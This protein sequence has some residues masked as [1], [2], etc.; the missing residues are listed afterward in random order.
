M[1]S[2][3]SKDHR[4]RY[5]VAI[6]GMG[7]VTPL[8]NTLGET[9]TGLVNGRSGAGPI[10]VL[11]ASPYNCKIAAEIKGFNPE[12]YIERKKTRHM[13][14]SSQLAVASALQAHADS[15]INLEQLDP[16]RVGLILGTAA[17]NTVEEAERATISLIVEKSRISPTHVMKFWP[18]ISAFFVAQS[19]SIQGFNSTVCTA[20][21][22]G[23]QAIAE[24]ARVIQRGDADV[25]FTG[26][27][28]HMVAETV[29][30]GFSAMRAL[31]TS[32]NDSPEKAMRPFEENRE[33]FIV[34]GGSAMLVLERLDLAMKRGAKIYAEVVGS[35]I[36]NDAF[37]M[38]A[39]DPQGKGAAKAM[40]L[41][42]ADAEVSID[43]VDY[44]N[45]HAA[46]T[47]LGDLAETLAIKTVFGEQAYR[48]PISSTKSMVGHLMGAAG[49]LEAVACAMTLTEGVIHPTINYEKPD[50]DCDLDYV[51][52]EA[53]D[54]KVNIALSNSIGLGGQ[55]ATLLLRRVN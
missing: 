43:V 16:Y 5:R 37:H 27:S 24:A 53:R 19:L 49:A 12:L 48:V 31:A 55:N 35:G 15:Q 44:I 38:I 8:G 21:A 26:G 22:A 3:N 36:T 47:L 51:P 17:G 28:D 52:N 40:R 10:T 13:P 30:A 25:M 9:W 45:A 4:G 42:L 29:L 46:S 11:D 18:N 41:A 54:R 7:A 50:V 1:T 23:T 14:T 34:A 39:P 20:C 33:G 2:N 6:T 32:Y